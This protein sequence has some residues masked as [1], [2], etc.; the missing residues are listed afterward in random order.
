MYFMVVVP[1]SSTSLEHETVE[2]MFQSVLQ[3]P[4][5]PKKVLNWSLDS[6]TAQ[7][8]HT[9]TSSSLVNSSL[10]SELL[11]WLLG[12]SVPLKGYT[13]LIMDYNDINVRKYNADNRNCS[14]LEWDIKPVING[15]IKF[16]GCLKNKYVLWKHINNATLA[17][18]LHACRNSATRTW[19]DAARAEF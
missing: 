14:S 2:T 17:W 6:S 8:T 11:S 10:F 12:Y 16:A 19:W 15:W 3:F 18:G 4:P 7:C 5:Y 1:N 13:V 9:V